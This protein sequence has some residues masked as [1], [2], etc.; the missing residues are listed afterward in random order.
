MPSI[1]SILG[2]VAVGFVSVSSALPALPK[3]NARAQAMYE[4]RQALASTGLPAG[5]TDIDILQFALTLEFLETA[6]YQQGFAKFAATDF[7]AAGLSTDDITN[8][9]SIGSTEQVHVTT[10]LSAIAA[11]G[12]APA[13]PCTYNFGFTTAEAMVAT[14]SV[15]ENIGVSAYLG[16]APLVM[17]PSVLTV[18]AEI[19]TV[20]ARHQTFI[21]TASKATAVPS[22]FDTPLGIRS[23][24]TL[25]AGF[26]S[27]CPTGSNLAI[28]PFATLSMPPGVSA[29]VTAGSVVSLVT[30]G[31][32]SGTPTNCAFTNGGLP[33]GSVFT[34][35]SGGQCTI[36]QNLAGLTY[37]SLSSSAPATG[38]LTDA[39][40][41]AGP[42]VMVVS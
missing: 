40:T 25:A 5:L 19:V 18:A 10:L 16:A 7:T 38:I 9:Q 1:R 31:T 20:E 33:G 35:F 24:F 27:S 21:R 28:T 32:T 17:S 26:I 2:A 8:L 3:L 34:P 6:F 12:Q 15:L 11:S 22:A 37:V 29:A 39:L 4:R 42:M 30:N 23:V 14:A 36:P 13:E 41:V